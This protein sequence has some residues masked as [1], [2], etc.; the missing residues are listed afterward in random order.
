MI[1]LLE[2]NVGLIRQERLH[3]SIDLPLSFLIFEI[4]NSLEDWSTRRRL[5]PKN[6]FLQMRKIVVSE[7]DSGLILI[8]LINLLIS[9]GF[10]IY[11][12]DRL[13]LLS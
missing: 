13:V 2:V 4:Q 11:Q 6:T 1:D 3:F 9:V 10:D 12:S 7:G 5:F 8:I